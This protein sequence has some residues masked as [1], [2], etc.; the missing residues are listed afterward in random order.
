ML[1]SASII[2]GKFMLYNN[3]PQLFYYFFFSRIVHGSFFFFFKEIIS[4]KFYLTPMFFL[5]IPMWLAEEELD[6][7]EIT[8]RNV[9]FLYKIGRR[10]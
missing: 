4:F 2:V 3:E 9:L 8:L 10:G 7:Y 1:L 6:I 5:V